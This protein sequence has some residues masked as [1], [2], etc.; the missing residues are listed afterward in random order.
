MKMCLFMIIFRRIMFRM[1]NVYTGGVEK[2][3][4]HV[5]YSVPFCETR[6]VY[7]IMREKR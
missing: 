2:I 5:L 6:A 7:E 1:G 3:K 4:P